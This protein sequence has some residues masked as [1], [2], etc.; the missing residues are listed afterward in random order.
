MV[1]SRLNGPLSKPSA[2]QAA[3]ATTTEEEEDYFQHEQLL[4]SATKKVNNC[5]TL[6]LEFSQLR[7]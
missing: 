4:A 7:R 2:H 3:T 1:K 5:F 6:I